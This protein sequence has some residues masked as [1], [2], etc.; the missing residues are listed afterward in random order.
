VGGGHHREA[1]DAI[2][3]IAERK[4]MSHSFT[5]AGADPVDLDELA[6]KLRQEIDSLPP[7]A[8]PDQ[9]LKASF[10]N[11]QSGVQSYLVLVRGN[12]D[13]HT[14]PDGDLVI[15][16]LEGGGY[17]QL[18]DGTIDTPAGS[19]VI[20][21]KGVCH[22]YFNLSADDSVILATFSPVNSKGECPIIA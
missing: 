4:N 18:S 2:N 15:S 17:I 1:V 3:K 10:L 22:A 6:N 21:P 8:P 12:E 20:I 14:H 5:V 11:Q 13:P 9:K 19:V 7:E 16:V